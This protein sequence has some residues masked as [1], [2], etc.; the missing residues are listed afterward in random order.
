METNINSKQRHQELL[1]VTETHGDTQEEMW[2]DQICY[3]ILIKLSMLSF[4]HTHTAHA[5]STCANP[6]QGA[7][8]S[9]RFCLYRAHD[10]CLHSPLFH[11]CLSPPRQAD[12]HLKVETFIQN[13]HVWRSHTKDF[14]QS[15]ISMGTGSEMIA[16]S[17]VDVSTE[18]SGVS[19]RQI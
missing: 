11:P 16:G 3:I 17:M 15:R 1:F 14:T 12:R 7:L 5:K 19:L 6:Q 8:M 18:Y 9:V 10:Y 2:H 4:S 13:R